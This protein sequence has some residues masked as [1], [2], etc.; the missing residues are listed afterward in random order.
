MDLFFEQR[1]RNTIRMHKHDY[2]GWGF[3]FITIKTQ[4]NRPIFGVINSGR[5]LLNEY[6]Q[7]AE[8][9]WKNTSGIRPE[10]RIDEFIIMPDHLHGIVIID[11]VNRVARNPD[12]PDQI[13][14]Q[15]TPTGGIIKPQADSLASILRGYKS[16]VSSRINK[17]RHSTQ[18]P[19]WQ[20]N[21]YERIIRNAVELDN[22]R[23]YIR[24]NPAKWHP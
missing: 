14:P 15:V 3:Y 22:V 8:E 5:M 12:Q 4:G 21:Y 10:V 18:P 11:P 1:N 7:I 16:A 9:E 20:R 6:G 24:N 2:A 13:I 23:Q 19:I 17:I